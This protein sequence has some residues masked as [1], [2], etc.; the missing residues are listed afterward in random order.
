MSLTAGQ[1]GDAPQLLTLLERERE[2]AKVLIVDKGY[3]QEGAQG[4]K[5][6]GTDTGEG[7]TRG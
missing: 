3:D 2:K 1:A 6:T 4:K 5:G 7:A